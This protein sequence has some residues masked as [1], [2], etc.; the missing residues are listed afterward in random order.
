[1]RSEEAASHDDPHD[2]PEHGAAADLRAALRRAEA[3]IEIPP[4]LARRVCGGTHRAPGRLA[5][6]LAGRVPRWDAGRL[7]IAGA[8]A[9]AVLAGVFVGGFLAGRPH[10]RPHALG[11][12]A[13][14]VTLAVYNAERPCRPLRTI[15]CGIAVMATPR[16]TGAPIA[17]V[18]HGD[19]VR[20]DCVAV[21][22][23]VTDEA[24][25]ASAR[26][27]H[28]T[29]PGPGTA[30]WLPGVRTRNTTEIAPCADDH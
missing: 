10:G 14:P 13:P 19:P 28:V 8:T 15:E 5:G 24:G 18:W 26:W 12:G 2:G 1:M 6:R 11:A 7:V 21:G 27:Y 30:G 20:A 9:V 25:I 23:P 22:D 17:R 3:S 16:K 29:L 4:G